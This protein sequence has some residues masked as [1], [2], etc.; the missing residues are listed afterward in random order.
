MNFEKY[1]TEE[2][3]SIS[4][5]LDILIDSTIRQDEQIKQAKHDIDDVKKNIIPEAVKN[6]NTKVKYLIVSS[7]LSYAVGIIAFFVTKYIL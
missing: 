7:V 5:K 6:A 2:L 1:T 3:K 4:E